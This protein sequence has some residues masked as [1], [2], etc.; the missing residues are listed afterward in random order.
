MD[1]ISVGRVSS[2]SRASAPI[3]IVMAAY[4][5]TLPLP[6]SAQIWDNLDG[7]AGAL[8]PANLE[9]ERPPAPF[10]VTGTWYID[11]EWRF[12]P[13]PKLLPEAQRLYDMA[14]QAAA[15]GRAFNDVTGQCWP[16]GVPIVMTRVWPIHMIQLPTS[17]VMISNFENQVRWVFMDSRSHT[18]PDIYAPSYNGESMG[19]WERDT[20]VIDTKNFAPKNHYIDGVPISGDLHIT[21]RVRMINDGEGLEI[22][23]TMTD[24]ANWEGEWVSTKRYK[25]EHKVDFLEVHCLPDLNKGILGTSEEYSTLSE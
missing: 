17:I 22:V 4:V 10:D 5:G 15:E 21:E 13:L 24:A 25:R 12:L 20:L 16:P 14:R 11:S 23:Y 7:H 18:D 8:A 9:Q 1:R 6:A 19:R 2:L 3:F